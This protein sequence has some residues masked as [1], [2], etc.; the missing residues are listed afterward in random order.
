MPSCRNCEREVTAEAKFCPHCG[1]DQSVLFS[2][3]ERI[4][5]PNVP[6]VPQPPQQEGSWVGR[7]LGGGFGAG[8]GWTVGTCI[9]TSLLLFF[10]FIV[11]PIFLIVGCAALAS[12]GSGS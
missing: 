4:Q 5:T 2:P 10:V 7:G 8:V 12:L 11:L 1:Q 9:A 3:E 6:N